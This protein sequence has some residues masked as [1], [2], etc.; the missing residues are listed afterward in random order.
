MP[1][2]QD[3]HRWPDEH[4]RFGDYG[5][6][7]VAETLMAPL[8][9]LAEAYERL[10]Q[11]AGFLAE[12]DRD[13]Q[14]YVGRP[15]PVYHAER[16]SQHVGGARILL[17]REDLNHTGAHKI[18]NTVGQALVAR[19][20]GKRRIIAE[21]GAGQH[22]V[23]SATVAARLGMQCVVYMG[24][25]DIERQ[26]INVYRMKLLG[27]EV[28]PVTSG[29]KTLKDALNEAMRDWVTNVADT[30]YIIGTVAGPHPYPKMV[31]DFNAIV[32]REARAQVLA[33]YGRLPDVLTA[34]VGGGSNAIGLFHAFLNDAG[35]RIV[36]AEAAGE[37]IATGH[38]AASLAAGRPGVLHGNRTYVLCDDN[39]QITETHSISAGLDYPGVGPE[40]AFL[41]DA[42]RAEYVGVTDDEAMEAFHLLARTE[43][44]LAAL[45]SSHAVAQAMKLARELPKDG[46]VLCNLSGRGDKDVHTIAAREGVEV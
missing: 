44:I 10:R 29:S 30:F 6:S 40:H 14:H 33:Q 28:V 36:G 13:L 22:G 43:G 17:K 15:S 25:V 39:G 7:Y 2:I 35:V 41:K 27:A 11:D 21:T 34:C 4:G 45:E 26:K 18:N 1:P 19:H 23:A 24:A 32:G 42:G 5:G 38:H 20:M 31:R 3:Y 12:L 8:A 37:G 46:I 16:L 9:E